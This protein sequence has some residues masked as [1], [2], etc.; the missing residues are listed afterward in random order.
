VNDQ[1]VYHRRWWILGV[2]CLSLLVIGLDNT[3]LN[4]ALPTLVRAIHASNSQLQWMVDSYTLVFAGLLLTAGSLGDRFGRRYALATGLAIFGAGSVLSAFAGSPAVLILTRSIMGIGSALIMPATLS[5]LTNVFPPAERGRAIGIWAGVS[6]LGIAIGPVTGGW[7]LE[8]FWWGSVFLVN[9]PVVLFA[10]VMGRLIVPNSK[11]PAAPKLDL[12]GAGLSIV[13][14][15][16]LV[17]GII[18]APTKGWG[19]SEILG[20]FGIGVLFLIVFV[21]WELRTEHPMLN[22]SFFQNARFTA[23][24]MSVTLVF[25]ALFGSLFFLTQY[26]QFM[27]GYTALQAGGR[28]APIALAIMIAAP[29]SGRLVAKL[30]NKVMVFVGMTIVAGG[31][32][33]LSRATLSSGYGLVAVGLPVLGFGMGAAMTPATESIMGSL[34]LGKAGVGS[35]MNDTTRQIGGALGVAVLGSIM[36]SV[37]Q[38]QIAPALH[39]LPAAAAA[40]AKGSVGAAIVIGNRIGG[41]AGQALADAARTSFIHAMDRG[42]L[43]GAIVAMAGALV[44]LIWLPSRPKD[45]EAIEAE[46]ERVTAAVVPQPAGRLAE[47]A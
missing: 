47:R 35:A 43:A 19:S 6:G 29:T 23:A 21:A 36:T 18:E 46:L 31:L 45:A 34:P 33:L 30:G 28:V 27:L 10:L 14:L 26:L 37:Y 13:A 4:V 25:F 2:L 40:A 8:H 24:S 5:I 11:D 3:I 1:D 7:L 32:F 22:I 9:V 17:Y 16:S 44:S 39:L 12:V 41:A 20:A 15:V 38:S 42:L